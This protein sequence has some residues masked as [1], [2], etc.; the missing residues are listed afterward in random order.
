MFLLKAIIGFSLNTFYNPGF[1]FKDT[2]KAFDR[3]K[4][5]Q[6]VYEVMFYVKVCIIWKC[7]QYTIPRDKTEKLKTFPSEKINSTKNA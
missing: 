3:F 2:I 5:K 6:K 4:N 1:I 7:I